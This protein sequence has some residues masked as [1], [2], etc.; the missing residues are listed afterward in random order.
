MRMARSWAAVFSLIM[1]A[2]MTKM[3]PPVSFIFCGLFLFEH[4][5][6]QGLVQL[7]VG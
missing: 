4:D 6:V 5:Q 1:P 3:R 2:V 7:E